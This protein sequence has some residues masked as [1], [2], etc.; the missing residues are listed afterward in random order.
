MGGE[1]AE[2]PDVDGEGDEMSS[3]GRQCVCVCVCTH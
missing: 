3:V 1:Q 2:S